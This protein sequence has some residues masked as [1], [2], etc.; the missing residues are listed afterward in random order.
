[1]NS[2]IFNNNVFLNDRLEKGENS[3]PF[4]IPPKKTFIITD[5]VIQ[6]RAP[7]DAPV[8]ANQSS[9]ITLSSF[10]NNIGAGFFL[11]VMGNE[12]LNL[13]FSTGVPVQKTAGQEYVLQVQNVGSSTAPFIEYLIT[14]Y[15]APSAKK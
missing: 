7:G 14:G 10:A 11:T 2:V 5:I 15:L 12:T 9:R 4:I 3:P 13:H 8:D 6:N 1:M